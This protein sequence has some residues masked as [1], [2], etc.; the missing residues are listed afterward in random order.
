M[1]P[2]DA[3]RKLHGRLPTDQER[4][5]LMTVQKA[6]G[7]HD[8]DAFWFIVLMLEHY[9]ALY[10]EYPSKMAEETMRAIASAK[11]AF[12]LAATAEAAAV[13]N[14][15]AEEVAR[16]SVAM[17]RKL[18][19]RPFNWHW[20]TSAAAIWVTFGALCLTA[21]AKLGSEGRPFWVKDGASNPVLAAVLGAP[22]GWM[23]YALLLP[24][25]LHAVVGGW[26]MVVHAE[27]TRRETAVGVAVMAVALAATVGCGAMLIRVL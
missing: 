4:H 17:A 16:T 2:D 26:S 8:N 25:A 18:V 27:G 15:L 23:I 13:H 6:L 9:D 20:V 7:I 10:R 5:W 19:N 21:G 22:A 24:A 11:D 3:F 12:R 1:P 14:A